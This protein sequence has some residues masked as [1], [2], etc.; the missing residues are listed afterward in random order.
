MPIYSYK[1]KKCGHEFDRLCKTY[2]APKTAKCPECGGRGKKQL[3]HAAFTI[4]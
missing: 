3:T 4:K 1:C 2:D